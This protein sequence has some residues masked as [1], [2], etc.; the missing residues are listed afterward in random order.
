LIVFILIE[1]AKYY[2]QSNLN[3]VSQN[4]QPFRENN[5]TALFE[6]LFLIQAMGPTGNVFTFNYPS[7]S[8]GV[9]FYTYFIFGLLI[10]FFKKYRSILI[11]TIALLAL[12]LIET[13]NTYGMLYLLKCLAGFFIGC[14]TADLAKKI[15][16]K[17]PQYFSLII[18]TLIVVY[19]QT[20]KTGEYDFLIYF[21]TSSLLISLIFS[22]NGILK[23][24]FN[25]KILTLLGLI[26]YSV[27]MSHAA[28]LWIASQVV[29]AILNRP[30]V[31]DASGRMIPQLSQLETIASA[32][33]SIV[34]VL[35][36][37]CFV[38][39]FIEKPMRSKSRLIAAKI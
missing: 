24:I 25:L 31:L 27:Y 11:T 36:V 32:F 19:L 17:I 4:S 26:S 34:S 23:K 8:I 29:K 28:V 5:I 30:L 1:L 6:N 39:N 9:E 22:T 2:A 7:W 16:I 15:K 13:E 12:I 10:L 33:I 18:F 3:L 14:M 38:Y 21:L 37:S 20:K 35:I